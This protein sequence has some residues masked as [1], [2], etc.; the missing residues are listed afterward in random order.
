MTITENEF[1]TEN[2]DFLGSVAKEERTLGGRPTTDYKLTAHFAK[3]LSIK[4]SGEKA[5]QAREIRK[6]LRIEYFSMFNNKGNSKLVLKF[7]K[8]RYRI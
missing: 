6:K 4:G 8:R 2:E 7:T 5:E 1:A 3:K